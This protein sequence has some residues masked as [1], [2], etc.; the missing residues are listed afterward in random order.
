MEYTL[1]GSQRSRTTQDRHQGDQSKM[2]MIA[3]AAPAPH[4]PF[5][6][7]Y[8]SSWDDHRQTDYASSRPRSEPERIALPSIRQAFPEIH[9]RIV[10]Q[11]GPS[12]TQS[13]TTSPI[14]GPPG[15]MTP[16]EYVHSPTSQ[17]KRRRLSFDKEQDERASRVPRLYT[18]GPSPSFQ[19]RESH[20]TLSPVAL[21][22]TEPRSTA[23]SWGSS[24]RASPYLP[25]GPPPT[26]R[27]PV[28]MEHSESMDRRPTLPSLPLLNFDRAPPPPPPAS[29]H[30][31]HQQQ[32][33]QQQQQRHHHHQHASH[34]GNH[35]RATSGD[36]YV[37]EQSRM[38]AP[39][40][41][42]A[43]PMESL[44]GYR[45]GGGGAG[46]PGYPS[47]HPFHHPSRMQSLSMGSIPPM[48]R[49]PFS[50]S[51]YG[52]YHDY[53]RISE[54]GGMGLNGDNKQRKRRGNLPKET[55]DK[56]RAWF[57]A[58]LQHPY[59]TEDEK[60]ELMRQTG[61]QMN[62][63][64]NWFINARRRQLPTM[65]NNARA[66]SDAIASGRASADGKALPSTE[67][68]DYDTDGKL[69]DSPV[70]EDGGM[71]Y[72]DDLDMKRRRAGAGMKRG[73]V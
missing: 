21:S 33:Q 32:Q 48:D 31:H 30:H 58:H 42:V 66:E 44:V 71:H 65:I 26:M 28:A 4:A 69:R 43:S 39:H 27:S 56:L 7:E 53:M 17:N 15:T 12:G 29:V 49:M 72:D 20:H 40:H 46:S 64:S 16:P 51:A 23:D 45:P 1:P 25:G 61:L 19:R 2:S 55:T 5:K 11:D 3:M 54:L 34:H 24:S 22:A 50:P 70:S 6:R 67:R 8:F 37:M 36:D 63:I 38:M 73:S 10:P 35:I 60:Q 57:L 18:S 14:V 59:P 41:G 62:Q 13:S 52:S 47:Y 9:L 68:P